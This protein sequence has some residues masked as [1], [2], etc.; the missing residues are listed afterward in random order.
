MTRCGA[1]KRRAKRTAHSETGRRRRL[2]LMQRNWGLRRVERLLMLVLMLTAR[3]V[4][5]VAPPEAAEAQRVGACD[6]GHQ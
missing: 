6:G 5:R 4:R 3:L 2:R 1:A